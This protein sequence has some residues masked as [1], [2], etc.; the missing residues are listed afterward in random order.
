MAL[1]DTLS[2][3]VKRDVQKT[4]TGDNRIFGVMIGEVIQNYNENFPG[5]VCVAITSRED[6]ANVLQWCR[7]AMPSA[8]KN[9]GHYFL[10]EIGD[11]VLVAFEYGNIERPYVI[12]CVPR[13]GDKFEKGAVDANNVY[14]KITTRNGSTLTFVDTGYDGEKDKI[15]IQTAKKSHQIEL[16]NENEKI[17][18]ADKTKTTKMIYDTKNSR[19]NIECDDKFTV[20]VSDCEIVINGKKNDITIKGSNVNVKAGQMLSIT[21]DGNTSIKGQSV[22]IEASGGSVFVKSG[23]NITLNAPSVNI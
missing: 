21:S 11:Q 18:I 1:Y 12:G 4:E 5:R 9:W 20:K 6:D 19:I 22:S 13:E 10:P 16:D 15:Q 8:G 7:V 2:D 3:M 14:K 17:T 23:S